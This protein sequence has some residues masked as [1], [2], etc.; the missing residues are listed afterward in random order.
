MG[1]FD[2]LF[3]HPHRD[4]VRVYQFEGLPPQ[5]THRT[6]EVD[7]RQTK[8]LGNGT[9]KPLIYLVVEPRNER[10]RRFL[11]ATFAPHDSVPQYKA[12]VLRVEATAAAN[13]LYVLHE[14]TDQCLSALF[15]SKPT[16]QFIEAKITDFFAVVAKL[17]HPMLACHSLKLSELHP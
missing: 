14:D 12:I 13:Q 4:V 15:A 11:T 1:M 6:I 8:S 10:R 7:C 5:I 3:A 2:K 16:R 9:S 17:C